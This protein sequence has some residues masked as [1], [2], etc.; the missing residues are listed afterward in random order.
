MEAEVLEPE[1]ALSLIPHDAQ[2]AR[3]PKEILDGAIEAAT[4]LKDVISRKKKPVMFRGEQYL[5]YEDW[6]T[7][8]GFFGSSVATGDAELVE[9]DGVRGFRAKARIIDGNGIEVSGAEAYCM[10]DEDNWKTKPLFQLASMAQTRAGAKALRNKFAWVAVLAGYSPTPA[11][12]MIGTEDAP[13]PGSDVPNCPDCEG[14]MWDNRATKKGRQP[15]YK[16]KDK[17]CN[18]AVWL[19]DSKSAPMDFEATE[20]LALFNAIKAAGKTL[21][22]MGDKPEWTLSRANDFANENFNSTKGVDGLTL[23]QLAEM[24]K[25]LS[26]RIDTMK[27]ASKTGS[28]PVEE[29]ERQR[30]ITLCKSADK[31]VLAQVMSDQFEGKTINELSLD[32]L[33]HLQD[34]VFPF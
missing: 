11:E 12:E 4:A 17:N 1:T 15:D 26:A 24:A 19:E 16:C 23:P 9:I 34:Q 14:P 18:K 31:D 3:A 25:L 6:Q 27:A 33:L 32:S 20:R 22:S 29:A 5:Q 13:T 30:L 8:G 28:D 2:V 7:I 10:K 21:N